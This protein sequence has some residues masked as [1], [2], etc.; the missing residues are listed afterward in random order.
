MARTTAVLRKDNKLKEKNN[1]NK[2]V[3]RNTKAGEKGEGSK[4]NGGKSSK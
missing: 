4:A 2:S 3:N 1:K